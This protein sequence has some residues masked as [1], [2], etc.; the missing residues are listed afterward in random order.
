[1]SLSNDVDMV[2]FTGSTRAGKRINENATGSMKRVRTELG[3]KS[4]AVM[5]D[6]ADLQKQIPTFMGQLVGNTGQACNAL[7][8]MLIPRQNYEEAVGIAK[9]YMENVKV[10]K[11]TDP[12]ARIGALVS[13]V[14]WNRVQGYLNKG[15]E[16][17]A[18]VVTGGPGKPEGLEDGYFVKPTVF[19]DA[20]NKMTIAQEEI[21]GPVLTM[22][23]YDTEE[24]AVNIAND[25]VYGLNN[26][27]GSRDQGR[28]L[29]I[30]AKLKSGTVMVNGVGGDM[31]A[32]FGGRKSSGDARE[33]GKYGL[34]EYLVT[35]T[36]NVSHEDYLKIFPQ[37]QNAQ[38]KL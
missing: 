36:L 2:S 33:W 1:M 13:E 27:V 19:A 11:S 28:A 8:R 38:A 15:I 21:F 34:E 10:G 26:A 6:D 18:R 3:G 22:I 12:K 35:K 32:P 30:A 14:Q 29:K 37:K 31:L 25:T 7:S 20:N 24:E 23:P 9:N 17:G 4:A 5:L 16:E